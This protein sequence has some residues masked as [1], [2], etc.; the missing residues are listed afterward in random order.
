M[1][2]NDKHQALALSGVFQ[3]AYLVDKI[4]KDGQINKDLLEHAVKTILTLNPGSY[5]ELFPDYALF[6]NGSEQLNNAL[7]KN[8]QGINKE[9]LQYAMSIVTVQ[10]KL[11]KRKDLMSELANGLDR[12]VD[13]QAYFND[14]LHE[15]ILASTASCYQNSVSKLNFRIRVT[16]NPNHLRDS[17]VADQVR[18]ILL[19]GVRCALLWRHS[20]GRRW[21]FLTSR[22]RLQRAVNTLSQLA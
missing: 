20:G 5:E 19:Y 8:G 11:S 9:V 4:A 3:A 6:Q 10:G 15:S 21:H 2:T 22:T 17:K 16:G 13:Q 12:A 7:S 1:S 18:T 14:Y